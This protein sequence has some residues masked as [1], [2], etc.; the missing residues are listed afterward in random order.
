MRTTKQLATVT[1]YRT[2]GKKDVDLIR[3]TGFRAFPPL[4]ASQPV[5]NPVLDESYAVKMARDWNSKD[6]GSDFAGYVTRFS[7][8]EDFIAGY[9]VQVIGPAK[10]KEYWIPSEE[11]EEL[12]GAIVGLIEVIHGFRDM[13]A[14]KMSRP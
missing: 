9:P 12:N 1:L 10:Q 13:P 6:P 2:L 8:R 5:I 11:L 14:V 7:V 4:D 3:A